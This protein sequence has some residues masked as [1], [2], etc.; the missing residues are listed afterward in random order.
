MERFWPKVC[1]SDIAPPSLGYHS[2][3]IGDM[4]RDLATLG[5][6]TKL[7]A[8]PLKLDSRS[9]NSYFFLSLQNNM[10]SMKKTDI[11]ISKCGEDRGCC[12]TEAA[13]DPYNMKYV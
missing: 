7:E 13:F 6:T 11:S 2:G 12:N 3:M 9:G 4:M 10:F 5:G 1:P 8:E